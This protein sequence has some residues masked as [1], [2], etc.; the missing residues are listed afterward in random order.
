MNVHIHSL[1]ARC[2]AARSQRRLPVTV[3]SN[4]SEETFGLFMSQGHKAQTDKQR[5]AHKQYI[6]SDALNL[7][8]RFYRAAWNASAD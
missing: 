8:H 6:Y 7:S 4:D 5:K 1:R 3:F 2:P